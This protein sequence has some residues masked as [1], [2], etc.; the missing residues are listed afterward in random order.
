MK[1]LSKVAEPSGSTAGSS[2]LARERENVDELLTS[3]LGPSKD[4]SPAPGESFPWGCPWGDVCVW[5]GGGT[6]RLVLKTSLHSH[7]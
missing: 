2:S 1:V 3:I 4:T 6:D 5:M 7:L